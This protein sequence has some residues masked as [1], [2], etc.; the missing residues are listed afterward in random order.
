MFESLQKCTGRDGKARFLALLLSIAAHSVIF[1]LIVILPLVFFQAIPGIDLVTLLIAAPPVPEVPPPPPPRPPASRPQQE[2]RVT[3]SRDMITPPGMPDFIPAPDEEPAVPYSFVAGIPPGLTAPGAGLAGS[4]LIPGSLLGHDILPA[5]PPP[6]P[7]PPKKIAT[8]L[9][10]G[11]KVQEAK[12]IRKILPEY[13]EIAK[14]ARVSGEVMLEIAVDEEGNVTSLKVLHG[15]PLLVAEAVRVVRQWK[16]SPT[17]LNGEPVPI[18]SVV[19][20]IFRL[21]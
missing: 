14:K 17:L 12:L 2:D 3:V 9:E 11:G 8:P 16:Y 1:G 10:I 15:H 6:P 13:P 21:Q 7:P 18:L 19:T 20:I 4:T 5:T